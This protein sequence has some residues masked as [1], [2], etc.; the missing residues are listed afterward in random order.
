[1]YTIVVNDPLFLSTNTV[2]DIECSGSP[3]GYID[4]SVSGGTF[5]YT[6]SWTSNNGFSATTEDVSNLLPGTY[7]VIVTDKNGCTATISKEFLVTDTEDPT[8][9]VPSP[10]NLEDCDT[11]AITAESIARFAFSTT[12]VN[13]TSSFDNGIDYLAHDDG[14]IQSI[15]YIDVVSGG[16]TWPYSCYKNIYN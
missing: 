8:I 2:T 9:Q 15:T 16:T 6:Y 12:D 7:N 3:D 4:L 1:M 14:T 11:S 13:I 10:L 5:P